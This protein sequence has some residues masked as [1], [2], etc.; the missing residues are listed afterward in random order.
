MAP[1]WFSKRSE[2]KVYLKPRPGP[3]LFAPERSTQ[4]LGP[5][6]R[7]VVEPIF[8]HASYHN[9]IFSFQC[10]KLCLSCLTCWWFETGL[11]LSTAT[12]RRAWRGRAPRDQYCKYCFWW[13]VII[14][15]QIGGGLILWWLSIWK[16]CIWWPL[17]AYA[18][19]WLNTGSFKVIKISVIM[20]LMLIMMMQMLVMMMVLEP[21]CPW[22]RWSWGWSW[23]R[24]WGGDQGGRCNAPA[25]R[26]TTWSSSPSSWS[27][28]SSSWSS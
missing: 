13:Q 12:L 6:E 18:L 16:T 2:K 10:L 9:H 19:V 20:M 15:H 7:G 23:G 17:V 21:D 11:G 4:L 5:S 1:K 27:S 26:I 3:L 24:R 22:E 28:S 8:K 25:A 14:H